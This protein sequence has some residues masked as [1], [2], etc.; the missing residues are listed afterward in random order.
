MITTFSFEEFVLAMIYF[1]FSAVSSVIYM[2]IIIVIQSVT[3]VGIPFAIAVCCIK[4]TETGRLI[5]FIHNLISRPKC[6]ISLEPHSYIVASFPGFPMGQ[7]E[8]LG[9]RL[10]T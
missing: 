2:A 10:V 7:G 8:N 9:T 4:K 5:S 3:L 6:V 1:L